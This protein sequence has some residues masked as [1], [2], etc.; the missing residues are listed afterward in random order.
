MKKILAV[1]MVFCLLFAMSAVSAFAKIS[2][3]KY[4]CQDLFNLSEDET[5]YSVILYDYPDS[6]RTYEFSYWVQQ[7]RRLEDV[8]DYT[9]EYGEQLLSEYK[10]YVE[11]QRKAVLEAGEAFFEK[12]FDASTDELVC[13]SDQRALVMVKSTV[14]KAKTLWDKEDCSL[15]DAN[16]RM[17]GALSTYEVNDDAILVPYESYVNTILPYELVYALDFYKDEHRPRYWDS[18]NWDID[19]YVYKPLYYHY[20]VATTNET[21]VDEPDYLLLFA[22]CNYM[23]PAYSAASFGD[24][25]LVQEY[26]IYYPYTL[27]MYIL[28]TKDMKVYNLREAWDMEIEGIEDVFTDYGLGEIRGDSDGDDKITV[29]DA[30]YIQKCI[31]GI[32][33]FE[34]R[35]YV[36]GFGEP[37]QI[38]KE[39][40]FSGRVS[41]M[42][43]DGK[44]NVK[45]A[46]AIQKFVAGIPI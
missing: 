15:F 24:V 1:F 41:D 3:N 16:G 12:Y 14:A 28:T 23:S 35:E 29:K 2:I 34:E 44:V 17:E 4:W 10:E 26:N 46:T 25:Y 31:A 38:D 27:G 13:N 11:S 21:S 37:G 22:G 18:I 40:F 6:L 9:I 32:Q 33:K 30:T 42:D 43:M 19:R 7:N 8:T 5:I 36:H 45:D 20:P 39:G